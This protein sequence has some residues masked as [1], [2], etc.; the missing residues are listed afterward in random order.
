MEEIE[1][2]VK[3]GNNKNPLIIM[4]VHIMIIIKV[5]NIE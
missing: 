1:Y 2:N 3:E 5:D 4:C